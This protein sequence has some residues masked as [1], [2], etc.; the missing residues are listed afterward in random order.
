MEKQVF[1][2]QTDL[3]NDDS[4]NS[5]PSFVW[6]S[7]HKRRIPLALDIETFTPPIYQMHL[8]NN[9]FRLSKFAAIGLTTA[10]TGSL[11]FEG[12]SNLKAVASPSMMEFRW[13]N[14][15]NYKKLYYW[16]SSK[17]RR[18]RATY[19]LALKSR[20]RRTAILKLRITIPDYFNANIPSKKL[21]LCKI[22]LGGMLSKTK[23]IE[24]IPAVFEVSKDQSSIEVFPNKPISVDGDYAV[25]MKI[26]NPTKAG[27]FQ[28]NAFAQS[29]GDVP[30]SSYV[31][32]WSI[33]IN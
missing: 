31:G 26:F 22:S 4:S 18:D 5:G 9:W 10:F 24:K 3:K 25:V 2:D 28:L 29:P 32:S 8:H 30:I 27:M 16:Q 6:E 13:D 12:N 21:S 17:E 11:V 1:L 33:D 15:G 23:C 7:I 19:Y 14:T 20:D